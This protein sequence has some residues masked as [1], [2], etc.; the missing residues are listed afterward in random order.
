MKT[1]GIK[2]K[3]KKALETCLNDT[4]NLRCRQKPTNCGGYH[5]KKL[6][7]VEISGIHLK[8]H[9]KLLILLKIFKIN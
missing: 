5:L 3:P 6:R 2:S 4:R 9:E 1:S 8:R 7:S